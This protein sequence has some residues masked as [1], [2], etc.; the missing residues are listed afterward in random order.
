MG[1]TKIDSYIGANFLVGC[2]PV[3]F[4]LLTLFSFLGLSE[5]LADV[6][7][8]AYELIDALLVV[9]YSLPTLAV[10]LLPVTTLLGGLL[11]LGAL[12]NNQEITSMRAAS[13][14]P[15]RIALPIFILALVL[16]AL[17]VVLQSLVIPR[18]EYK[19]TQLR[20]KTLM[21]V[22]ALGLEE[23]PGAGVARE[24][25]TRNNGQFIRIGHVEP[26]RSLAAVEIYQFDPQGNLARMLQTPRALLLQNNTWLLHEV[27]ETLLGEA[28]SQT[29]LSE[30]LLWETLLS[31][32]QAHTLVTPASSLAPMDLW[33]SIQRLE[34][35]NMNSERHRVIFW[36]QMSAPLGLLGMSLLTIPF[37]LGSVRSVPVGQRIALGGVIG[38]SFYLL[39]QISGHLAGI[40]HWNVPLTVMAPGLLVLCVATILLKRLN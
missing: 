1:V 22:G 39:Q 11:G 9:V 13:I 23:Q 19:A 3:L 17:V 21:E 8:G 7:D 10:D 20:A 34:D 16:I 15:A 40:M 33:K 32:E 27:R 12:A 29:Q 25:W 38:I 24:F 35:N 14:S 6:G 26:D 28:G 37:L 4:L 36:K 18:V 5:E 30:T 2:L 31:E